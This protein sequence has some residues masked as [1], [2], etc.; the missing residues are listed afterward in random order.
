MIVDGEL[1]RSREGVIH[2]M[3]SRV[4]D[5]SPL[6]ARLSDVHEPKTTLSRA[7][8]FLNPANPRHVAAPRMHQHPRNVRLLPNS[9]DFH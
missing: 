4:T 6:L 3:A 8:V 5:H 7:D 1:Q 2:I 9:R